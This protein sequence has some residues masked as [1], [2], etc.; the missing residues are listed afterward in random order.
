MS[1]VLD[2]LSKLFPDFS[3]DKM[4]VRVSLGGM[5]Y[6]NEWTYFDAS[7]FHI[8]FAEQCPIHLFESKETW[9]LPLNARDRNSLRSK[10]LEHPI[11]TVAISSQNIGNILQFRPTS[12]GTQYGM[13]DSSP[14][15]FYCTGGSIAEVDVIY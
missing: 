4:K 10:N 14:V 5:L 13:S 12:N 15:E 1:K 11:L 2:N 8:L 9:P 7:N 6:Q 3:W